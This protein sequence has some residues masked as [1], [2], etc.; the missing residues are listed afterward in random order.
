LGGNV[1]TARVLT[2]TIRTHSLAVNDLP[3]RIY[4]KEV[5][6]ISVDISSSSSKKIRMHDEWANCDLPFVGYAII[7]GGPDEVIFQFT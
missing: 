6:N 2:S 1:I 5:E 3:T 4:V 7:N